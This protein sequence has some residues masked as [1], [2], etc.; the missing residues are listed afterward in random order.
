MALFISAPF[1]RG[2]AFP[3]DEDLVKS[4]A[5]MRSVNDNVMPS[6]Y[7][8]ICE[9]DGEIYTYKKSNTVDDE[10]GK[11]RLLETGAGVRFLPVDD[12]P[13][14][15]EAGVIYLVPNG[16][17]GENIKDEYIWIENEE[18]PSLSFYEKIGSTDIELTMGETFTTNIDVGGVKSGT[19]IDKDDNIM[20]VIKKML[21][22][23]YYPTYNAP[24]ANLSYSAPAL[25]KVG[26]NV[27]ALAASVAFNAGA[28]MLQGTKQANRAGEATSFSI[29][30][31]GAATDYTD[32]NDNGSFNMP[33]LTRATKGNITVVGTVD[34]AE[35]PQPKDSNNENYGEPLGAGSVNTSTKTI[36]F[37][38]PFYHGVNASDA[39]S[40][41][42]GMTEDL[43][44]KSD[45]TYTYEANNEYMYLAYDSSYNDLTA[46]KDEN[47]LENLENFVKTTI[48]HEGQTYKCYRS[49]YA[50]TG[51]PSFIFK[52]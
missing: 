48:T 15:G 47:N 34:Y 52:F 38:L 16:S 49:I 39:I 42:T 19:V 3:V 43:S 31:S 51:S 26:S 35:G 8:C 30:T 27:S 11:Y 14:T 20:A 18:D 28:I 50:I 12:L 5:Q 4:K 33:A 17:L 41:L 44:K 37:I 36:E 10:T 21:T 13:D 45:K 2:G 25:A 40:D 7:F 32:T 24:S 1:K 22:T 6:V 46:I 29:A 9:D 23:V